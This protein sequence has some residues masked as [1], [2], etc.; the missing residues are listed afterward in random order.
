MDQDQMLKGKRIIIT[1][2][3]S[4]I[5]KSLAKGLAEIGAKIGI[6]SRSEGRL[7][8]IV[9]EIEDRGHEAVFAL[10]DVQQ[11][12]QVQDGVTSLVKRLGGVDVLINNAGVMELN[13]IPNSYEE[14]DRIIDTNLKGSLY[15]AL[16]VLPYFSAQESGTIIN[17]SSILSLEQV[18]IYMPYSVVYA[19][20]KAGINMMTRGM[21]QKFSADGIQINAILPGFINTSMIHGI[22]EQVLQQ[23]GVM[24]TED[25]V[26]Y[27][28][29]F[30]ANKDRLMT[31]RL[32]PV[33]IFNSARKY[34]KKEFGDRVPTWKELE[35]PMKKRYADP[36]YNVYG[37][38]IR[39]FTDNRDLLLFLSS[40]NLPEILTNK[41]K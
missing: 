7:K 14:I 13:S 33:E 36:K 19:M 37:D 5:G 4:G 20:S 31:G 39:L 40:W 22:P 35:P 24:Q 3:S 38:A 17:T 10:G 28:A 30:A 1:G 18:A 21:A 9:R 16:A 2:A 12:S 26:A 15:C 11:S 41:D 34:I 27:Y 29:F 6:L 23:F 8:E 25:L 32:I